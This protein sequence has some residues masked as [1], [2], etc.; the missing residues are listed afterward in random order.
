M[1]AKIQKKSII[2]LLFKTLFVIDA[3]KNLSKKLSDS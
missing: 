2:Q 3:K 1:G